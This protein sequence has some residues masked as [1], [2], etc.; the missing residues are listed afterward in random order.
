MQVCGFENYIHIYLLT[1]GLLHY[2]I[3]MNNLSTEK[4]KQTILS[5]QVELNFL[6]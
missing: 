3:L 5:I 2:L 6:G 4:I 1:K